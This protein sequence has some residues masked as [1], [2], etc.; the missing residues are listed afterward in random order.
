MNILKLFVS[1]AF[2]LLCLGISSASQ[3]QW[4]Y[5]NGAYTGTIPSGGGVGCTSTGCGTFL[6]ATGSMTINYSTEL[7][8][9]GSGS[10]TT[11]ATPRSLPSVSGTTYSG[12][13]ASSTSTAKLPVNSTITDGAAN[14][15]TYS[16]D[17][18]PAIANGQFAQTLKAILTCTVN[19]AGQ[20][21][22]SVSY[23]LL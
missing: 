15:V 20:A 7:Y 11:G 4:A 6:S 9:Q 21:R 13:S 5:H 14:G 22:A 16:S 12:G 10:P 2:S 1:F 3:A 8:W 23:S 19:S 17:G 18:P